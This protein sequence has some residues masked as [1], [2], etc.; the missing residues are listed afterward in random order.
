MAAAANQT[1]SLSILVSDM[2]TGNGNRPP[3]M[4][5]MSEYPSWKD[6]FSVHLEGLDGGEA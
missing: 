4:L 3:K 5:D 2:M 1:N 6:R